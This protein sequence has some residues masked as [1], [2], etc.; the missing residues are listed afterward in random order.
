MVSGWVEAEFRREA[1]GPPT[2]AN[3]SLMEVADAVGNLIELAPSINPTAQDGE[4]SAD[5]SH[6]QFELIVIDQIVELPAQDEQAAR[7]V[8]I[9]G[10]LSVDPQNASIGSLRFTRAKDKDHLQLFIDLLLL[11]L[12]RPEQEWVGTAIRRARK[13]AK[14]IALS[15]TICGKTDPAQVQSGLAVVVDL[16]C[17]AQREALPMFGDIS[18]ACVAGGTMSWPSRSRPEANVAFGDYQLDELLALPRLSHDPDRAD[19]RVLSYARYLWDEVEA[20]VHEV[21]KQ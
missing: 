21:P 9:H 17:R 3:K 5:D 6:S 8:R 19:T 7:S 20:V 10:E 14:A 11:G 4:V 13:G 1:A 2:L 16:Y 18:R 15:G 12:V